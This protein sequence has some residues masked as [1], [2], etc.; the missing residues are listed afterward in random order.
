MKNQPE[1]NHCAPRTALCYCKAVVR[2][3]KAHAEKYHI[4]PDRIGVLGNYAGGH[5]AAMVA[6]SSENREMEGEVDGNLEFSSAV[7]SAPRFYA[8]MNFLALLKQNA[9]KSGIKIWREQRFKCGK[10][11]RGSTGPY[12]I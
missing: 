12:Y 7:K 5:L 3:I 6:M 4:N 2:F 1:L 8:P 10:S 11:P 9:Q